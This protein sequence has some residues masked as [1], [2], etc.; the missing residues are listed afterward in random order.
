VTLRDLAATVADL[1]GLP[2]PPAFS[3]HS[4]VGGPAPDSGQASPVV[5]EVEPSIRVAP[6][7]PTSRGP[8]RTIIDERLQYIL[9]GDGTEELYDYVADPDQKVNLASFA[10]GKALAASFR[11][12]LQRWMAKN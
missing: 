1:A 3:G 9:N 8:M 10:E 5:A 6:H 12:R 11:A 2:S 7:L 4:L